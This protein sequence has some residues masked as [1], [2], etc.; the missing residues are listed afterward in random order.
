MAARGGGGG[1]L[2]RDNQLLMICV[3]PMGLSIPP[4]V[5]SIS[6]LAALAAKTVLKTVTSEYFTLS[7]TAA[8]EQSKDV[9]TKRM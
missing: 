6:V 7:R 1:G 2:Q 3:W 8:G 9:T 4:V 5:L